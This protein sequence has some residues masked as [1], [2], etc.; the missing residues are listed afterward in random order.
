MIIQWKGRRK[1]L[2][3]YWNAVPVF[4]A[5][6]ATQ[7]VGPVG[8]PIFITKILASGTPGTIQ[9][10]A[11][12]HQAIQIRVSDSL[13]MLTRAEQW[14]GSYSVGSTEYLTTGSTW[15]KATNGD[16]IT[17]QCIGGGGA[18]MSDHS[19]G[20]G[21]GEYRRSVVAYVSN[22]VVS[23]QIGQG[24]L[25]STAT[26]G[27]DTIWGSNVII[28]KGGKCVGGAGGTGGTGDVG[29]DGGNCGGGGGESGGGG[30]GAAG[31][32]GKGGKGSDGLGVSPSWAGG[33]GGNGGGADAP[34]HTGGNNNLGYGGG[35]ESSA[36]TDGG[37]GGGGYS[38]LSSGSAGGKGGDG[39]DFDATHGSG[40]GGGGGA[41]AKT[42]GNG[43]LYGG[44]G[45][46]GGSYAS[47]G[48]GANGVIVV[49]YSVSYL[50][51]RVVRVT[52]SA[53]PPKTISTEVI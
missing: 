31:S 47:G 27:T 37:G 13:S 18:G 8:P 49:A 24:G 38:V 39:I 22:S 45:G 16:A 28:A 52:A 43:G 5:F 50:A 48:N 23:I 10:V 30:G 6:F 40:G 21:G 26:D 25:A 17:V 53:V 35:A 15:S 41:F 2:H 20:G 3:S 42:G 44:G 36:G 1:H 11:A 51:P 33:G 46:G 14:A 19:N 9:S 4:V 12:N 7:A 34:F 32:N 29:F